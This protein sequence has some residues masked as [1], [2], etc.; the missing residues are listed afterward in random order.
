MFA[1]AYV[2]LPFSDIPPAEAIRT[3][4]ARFQRGRPGDVPDSWIGFHD[5]TKWVQAAHETEFRF[6]IESGKFTIL[7]GVDGCYFID[8]ERIRHEMELRGLQSWTVRFADKMDLATFFDRFG[9]EIDTHPSNGAYGEWHNVLGRWDWWDLGG[10]FDGWIT[11]DPSKAEGRRV[12]AI[13]SGLSRGRKILS[14]LEDTLRDALDQHPAPEIDV[15]ND[16]NIELAETILADIQADPEHAC[17]GALV[18]P[19]G[20]LEDHL[21]WLDC[22]PQVGPVEAFT[23]LGIAADATWPEVVEGACR[24]FRDHWVAGVAF[25]Y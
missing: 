2:I 21:R 15:R 19:P 13:S 14:N 22:W 9:P 8:C 11:R 4:L 23:R 20:S 18:L 10:R 17:P 5:E 25:H 6:V 1:L 12:S 16:R 3:S 7:A 24:L